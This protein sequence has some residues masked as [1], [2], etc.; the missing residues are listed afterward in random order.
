MSTVLNYL[1]NVVCHFFVWMYDVYLRIKMPSYYL[2]LDQ[3]KNIEEYYESLNHSFR[4]YIFFE[5]KK[6]KNY[7]MQ[8]VYVSNECVFLNKK[9]KFFI[10]KV[11]QQKK[12]PA[13]YYYCY[14][15][16]YSV[17]LNSNDTVLRIISDQSNQI[18]CFYLDFQTKK[19][20]YC[21]SALINHEHPLCKN[22]SYFYH[23]NE[24]L[25]LS[26]NQHIPLIRLGPTT[27]ELKIKLGGEVKRFKIF[28]N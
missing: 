13:W 26:F 8:Q 22:G 4:K 17:L 21:V 7:Q 19:I 20:Y 16:F 6:F 27:D 12:N 9:L 18:I 25:Q 28:P 2:H 23:I 1:I 5:M 24:M 10:W 15:I 3:F 11:L 14:I